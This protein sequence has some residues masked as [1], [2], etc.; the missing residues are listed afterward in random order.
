MNNQIERPTV[1]LMSTF[2]PTECGIATFTTDLYHAISHQFGNCFNLAKC[3]LSTK[4]NNLN[5]SEY[6]LNPKVQEDYKYT[7]KAINENNRIK[8]IHIQHEFGLF[9]GSYGSYL[10]SFLET[11]IAPVMITFHT[12]LPGPNEELKKV[13]C[14]LDKY[15]SSIIVMTQ[16]SAKILMEDYGISSEKI[17]I[18]PHGTH[19]N[20]WRDNT[21][22]KK[23][24][25]LFNR[26]VI[27]TF[28]LIGPGK[29]IETALRAL[30]EIKKKIPSVIYLIVGK[31]HPNNFVNGVDEYRL[32]LKKLAKELI[33]EDHVIFLDHYLELPE[34]LEILQATDLYLFTSKDPNQAVSGT[35]T[36]AMSCACPIIATSIPHTRELLTPDIGKIIEI[37]NSSQLAKY[38]IEILTHPDLKK[39][40]SLNA[41][42]KSRAT[43]W[44][45]I[46][47]LQAEAYLEHLEMI[48]ELKYSYDPIKLNHLKKLT[49]EFG[50][51][52]FSQIN[53][54][55][56]NSGYTLDDNARALI[57][58]CNYNSLYP[59]KKNL[60]LIAIY[61]NFIKRCQ[62]KDGSFINYIDRF[63]ET[64]IKN[65]YVNLEDSN[66]RAIWALGTLLSHRK[67]L[68]ENY[69]S[70]AF[71]ILEK[72]MSWI[73]GTMSPRSI[74]FLIKGIY[75]CDGVLSVENRKN[76]IIS[77]ADKL[78]TRYDLNKEKDW[79]W[80][81]EYMTYANS[82]LP[83][84][85][86]YAYK[87]TNEEDYK[88]IAQ[89]SFKFLLK[90]LFVKDTFRTFSN[91]GWYL[92]EHTNI[93]GYG[94][95]PIDVA[96][97]IEALALFYE[98]FKSP[99]HLSLL[100]K[101]FSWFLGNN[102]LKQFIYNPLTGGCHDG[103]EE[104]NVNLNQ[105]AE[106]T[107]C[108][109]MARLTVERLL[110]PTKPSPALY[111]VKSRVIK[112]RKKRQREL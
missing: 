65:D 36:Y 106:S 10:F 68:P 83:E 20:E 56:L 38:S 34:L 17:K 18:I 103:L 23:K 9:G 111:S 88:D 48:P 84:A 2:P 66:A 14:K 94:E 42:K 4:Y 13:V 87:V 64:H 1:L 92:K 50:I 98:T 100:K 77:L 109:L 27:S 76:L 11:I 62:T 95:Q 47:V 70:I 53:I 99:R 107:I 6:H 33:I 71:S 96:Y 16:Q 57:A 85:M 81:E 55:D 60:K 41:Y 72:S 49:T 39:E 40:M 32:F 112:S 104:K 101:A 105:G 31:T 54:P 24:Y 5:P 28:G 91:D 89:E 74:A 69:S 52:Q 80:F 29:S 12:V 51:I 78:V 79:N 43:I 73:S 86:L 82:V 8:L 61:L 67:N 7:A 90:K 44:E 93:K 30:P 59:D 15:V 3:Q 35:F 25:G 110:K 108:Y 19:L 45:N 46:A 22:I 102:H 75:L 37:N 21:E 26:Q 58:L 63:Q 97:T